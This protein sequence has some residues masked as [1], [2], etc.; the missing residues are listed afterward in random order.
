MPKVHDLLWERN[1]DYRNCQNCLYCIGLF[2]SHNPNP[3]R[4]TNG[5]LRCKR[6]HWIA[7]D[8]GEKEMLIAYPG[9]RG[10]NKS[11]FLYSMAENCEDFEIMD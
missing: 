4:F 10:W 5:V 7:G 11:K 2:G 6:G 9:D 1:K 8:F 3:I